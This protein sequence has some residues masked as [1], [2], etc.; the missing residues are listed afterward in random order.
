MK[1]FIAILFISIIFITGCSTSKPQNPTFSGEIEIE[2]SLFDS[3]WEEVDL[4]DYP[5]MQSYLSYY[6]HNED[7]ETY[8]V[9]TLS[10]HYEDAGEDLK[11]NLD[12]NIKNYTETTITHS[13]YDSEISEIVDFEVGDFP[14]SSFDI[15]AKLGTAANE[16][17]AHTIFVSTPKGIYCLQLQSPTAN[18]DNYSAFFEDV[19][20][21]L[22]ATQI[23]SA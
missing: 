1:S 13:T 4:S 17:T 18:Y 6:T 19:K 8:V 12:E 7:P 11:A 9:M 14:A 22:T 5:D 21:S 23:E 3:N 15:K 10:P 16:F 2:E 20:S